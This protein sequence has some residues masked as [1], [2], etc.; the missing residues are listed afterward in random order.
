LANNLEARAVSAIVQEAL[1]EVL[2]PH[3]CLC[4]AV[5]ELAWRCHVIVSKEADYD[6]SFSDPEIPFSIFISVP[7]QNDR[8]SLLRVAENI[9][10]ETMHLQ[11]SLFE[12]CCP[13]IDTASTW[14]LHSPWKHEQR[15][16]QGI[17]HGLY[18]FHVLR[19]M[20]QQTA[21][22]TQ[23]GADH[24]FALRRICDIEREINAVRAIEDSP[25]LTPAGDLLLQRLFDSQ[26]QAVNS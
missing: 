24:S 9:V 10:H 1:N 5:S 22:Y 2:Q 4:L 18:V 14:T 20:W 8:S 21:Q 17:L 23:N 11:L 26:A 16:A 13:L 7:T 3:Y 15:P 6:V 12:R 25:A 19:W